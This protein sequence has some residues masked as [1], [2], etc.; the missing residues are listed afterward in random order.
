MSATGCRFPLYQGDPVRRLRAHVIGKVHE[1]AQ[2]GP[3]DND[4]GF[5]QTSVVADTPIP[6]F[7]RL[8]EDRIDGAEQLRRLKVLVQ[9]LPFFFCHRKA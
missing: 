5:G 4:S 8:G 2:I 1:K 9:M 6:R 3:D 7:A